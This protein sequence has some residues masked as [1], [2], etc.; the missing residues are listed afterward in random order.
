MSEIT[1]NDRRQELGDINDQIDQ[2][3][4]KDEKLKNLHSLYGETVKSQL[5]LLAGSE[6][7]ENKDESV[8]NRVMI[9]AN[10]L[11]QI[12]DKATNSVDP[13]TQRT[14]KS[15][16]PSHVDTVISKVI[17]AGL[18][19]QIEA[20]AGLGKRSLRETFN[21]IRNRFQRNKPE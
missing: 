19:D 15:A 18:V 16:V 11:P 6:N 20:E 1:T 3:I 8:E 2:L 12:Y 5:Y 9:A 4:Q 10:L 14:D 21:A 7:R 13:I 17:G